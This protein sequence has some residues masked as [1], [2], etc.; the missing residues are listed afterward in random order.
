M[1]QKLTQEELGWITS[2]QA[3]YSKITYELGSIEVQRKELDIKRNDIITLYDKCK[4]REKF[5]I[6][7]LNEKYGVGEINIQTGEITTI[8]P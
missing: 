1:I 4:E 3:D 2:L 6:G 7:T 8:D 5:F